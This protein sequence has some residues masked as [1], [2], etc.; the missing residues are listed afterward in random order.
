MMKIASI[1]LGAMGSMLLALGPI[2]AS[3][4]TTHT[5]QELYDG[6]EFQSGN[7]RFFD[8]GLQSE[9]YTGTASTVDPTKIVVELM[10]DPSNPG[11]RFIWTTEANNQFLVPGN[12]TLFYSF[13]YQV[14]ETDS[15]ARLNG[16]SLFG[17]FILANAQ[18][19]SGFV[20]ENIFEANFGSQFDSMQV[21]YA[22][23][24]G[25]TVIEG[26]D[27]DSLVF[28]PRAGITIS[29]DI[30]L[31]GG[32]TTLPLMGV[33]FFDQNVSVVPIP[34]AVWL[35]GSGL[36]GLLSLRLRSSN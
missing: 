28:G 25:G 29:T 18:T 22:G 34:G 7:T 20:R 5:L 14:E 3:A 10:E 8:F 21:E 27:T 35:L 6:S 11:L 26:T 31:T 24:A 2:P 23:T 9:G 1:V 32:T 33:N 17:S 19:G 13:N 4:A 15:V 36:L 30:N 12:S 16:G